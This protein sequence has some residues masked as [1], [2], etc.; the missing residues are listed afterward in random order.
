[1]NDEVQKKVP[2]PS[3]SP[4]PEVQPTIVIAEGLTVSEAYKI[5]T[6]YDLHYSTVRMSLVT[7]LITF[8]FGLAAFLLKDSHG[9]LALILGIGIPGVFLFIAGFLSAHFQ[10]L[11][12]ACE[13]I[14]KELE[15][16]TNPVARTAFPFRRLLE[17]KYKATRSWVFDAGNTAFALGAGMFLIAAATFWYAKTNVPEFHCVVVKG[18]GTVACGE[19]VPQ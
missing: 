14:Q 15:Q 11:T 17:T 3:G 4:A 16:E 5:V 6:D 19:P 13:M 2:V 8:A 18:S 10:C 12:A 7:F 1:M 9:H